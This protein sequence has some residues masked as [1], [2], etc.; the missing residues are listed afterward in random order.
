VKR[1]A[2]KKLTA[3]PSTL[4]SWSGRDPDIF[5]DITEV[6]IALSLLSVGNAF[7]CMTLEL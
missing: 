6:S 5:V 3:N 1:I 7:S 2:L 4:A